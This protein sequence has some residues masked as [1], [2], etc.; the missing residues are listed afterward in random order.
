MEVRIGNLIV[1]FDANG[2]KR[3]DDTIQLSVEGL[4]TTRDKI[5]TVTRDEM[6]RLARALGV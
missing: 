1:E 2:P 4:S 5:G 3:G 6:G